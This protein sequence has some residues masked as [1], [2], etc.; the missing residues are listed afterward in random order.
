MNIDNS[1]YLHCDIPRKHW[2]AI[3]NHDQPEFHDSS[4]FACVPNLEGP[5]EN[6]SI[7]CSMIVQ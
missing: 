4:I 5:F 2:G 6:I 7:D 3:Q 1:I